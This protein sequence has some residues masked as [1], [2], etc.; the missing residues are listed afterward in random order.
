M[1]VSTHL[2]CRRAVPVIVLPNLFRKSCV[3]AFCRTGQFSHFCKAKSAGKVGRCSE[4]TVSR[5]T[6]RECPFN[7]PPRVGFSFH[8]VDDGVATLQHEHFGRPNPTPQHFRALPQPPP[9]ANAASARH[10]RSHFQCS[11][12]SCPVG[13][14]DAH[15]SRDNFNKN[16]PTTLCCD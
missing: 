14:E 6:P 11:T 2:A 16:L 10:L 15:L 13:S 5:T 12:D 4:D 9:L 7:V 1:R 8:S 3:Q